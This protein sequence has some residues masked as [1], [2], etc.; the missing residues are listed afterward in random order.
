MF[1]MGNYGVFKFLV[2]VNILTLAGKVQPGS[3]SDW[4]PYRTFLRSLLIKFDTIVSTDR[5]SSA[6]ENLR[7]RGL[8]I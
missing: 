1:N 4:G 7:H 2:N 5:G 8:W 6:S 3:R